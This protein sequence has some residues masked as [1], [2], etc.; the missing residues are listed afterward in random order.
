[1]E[2]TV[3]SNE[4]RECI[5]RALRWAVKATA[6]DP[7]VGVGVFLGTLL[8]EAGLDEAE[9]LALLEQVFGA[10]ASDED[11]L[12]MLA[13]EQATL[14]EG[15]RVRFEW[16]GRMFEGSVGPTVLYRGKDRVRID[17]D[18]APAGACLIVPREA[19]R[20]RADPTKRK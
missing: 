1:M 12:S 17:I 9:T 19:L 15:T 7:P 2:S 3:E 10:E 11:W 4:L 14:R 16:N 13:A 6:D 8:R 18:G 20:L 5:Y